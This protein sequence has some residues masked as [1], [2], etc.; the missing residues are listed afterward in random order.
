MGHVHCMLMGNCHVFQLDV[1]PCLCQYGIEATLL[2]RCA[3]ESAATSCLNL[4]VGV[5][6]YFVII[7]IVY[8][9]KIIK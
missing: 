1:A 7:D 5:H 8:T 9:A 4:A 6:G 3:K 2:S